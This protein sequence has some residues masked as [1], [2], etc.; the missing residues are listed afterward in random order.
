MPRNGSGIYSKPSGTTAVPGQTILSDRYNEQVDDMVQDLNLARPITAGG[1]GATTAQA[2]RSALG[3][4]DVTLGVS[5]LAGLESLL[6]SDIGVGEYARDS[7]T[8]AI[9]QRVSSDGDFDYSGTSGLQF[10]VVPRLYGHSVK[11]FG[12][13]GDYDGTTGTDDTDAIRLAIN[14]GLSVHFPNGRYLVSGEIEITKA[15]QTITFAATGGY[16]YG[17]DIGLNWEY[18]TQI[19]VASTITPRIRTRRLFRG[20][21]T[22]PQD[23]PLSVVFNIQAE[24]VIMV[25][26]SIWLECDYTDTSPTNF[27]SDCDVGIFIGS[28]VGVQIHD[29]QV[30]GYFRHSG[31]YL[32]VSGSSNMPRFNDLDGNPYPTGTVL[33]GSDG[34]RMTNPYIRGPRQGFAVLGGKPKAGE[35]GYS[36]PYYDEI[37]AAAVTDGRGSFGASDMF[38]EQ[39]RIYGP[40]HHS[41][42][43]LYDPNGGAGSLNETTLLAEDD[44]APC[45]VHLDGLAGNAS[46]SI[47]G[48][49]FYGTRIATFEAFRLRL[50]NASRVNLFGCHIEGR[51]S[52]S[53]T[54]TAGNVINSND[55][56]DQ[57]YGDISGTADSEY[58]S[59]YGSPR[60]TLE[61]LAPH[62]YS[63][64]EGP[65]L[66]T[67]SG[68]MYVPDYISSGGE[69]DIR[70]A[71][72][73]GVRFRSGSTTIATI[74]DSGGAVFQGAVA[75]EVATA[76]DLGDVSAAINTDKKVTGGMV[77]DSTNERPVWAAG[78]GAVATWRDATGSVVFSPS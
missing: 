14:T 10:N 75:G 78:S 70:G 36:D 69:T 64:E 45:A 28:R 41:D 63:D 11:D 4:G 66:V 24:G 22:D 57:S 32:D 56:V 60:Q 34:F 68:R 1:T 15:G 48:L 18:N 46:G 76:S 58:V 71:S 52:G 33:N 17:D 27:G 7:I 62:F 53:R 20:A 74:N 21:D 55:Y 54:D 13:A 26:P 72:G 8:G 19:V 65:L 30:I 37:L 16:G 51:N 3:I 67:D 47:W 25:R 40:D 77:W 5:G 61:D 35:V 42:R 31:I 38:I 44:N 43:R 6:P 9:Y 12:A 39:G 23:D 73:S 50:G 29:P 2:A 49:R 59:V